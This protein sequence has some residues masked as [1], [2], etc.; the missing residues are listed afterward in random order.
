MQIVKRPVTIV[1]IKIQKR[2]RGNDIMIKA[3]IF[4]M[5]ETLIT[6]YECPLYF[7]AQMSKDAGIEEQ[8]FQVLWRPTEAERT[9]GK[10]T[11]EDILTKILEANHCYSKELLQTIVQKR[12]ATKEEC[13]RHLHNEILP[14]F[15]EIKKHGVKIGLISNCFSEE[16]PVI[17]KSILAPYFDAMYLSYEQGVKKPDAEIY[18]RC[19]NE[20]SVKPE[21]CIYIGDGGSNELEAAKH[22][23]MKAMQAAWY[24]KEGT[25]QP[26]RRKA[27]FIQLESPLE[28]ITYL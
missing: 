1:T 20:L 21:E 14:M 9:I 27:A 22:L 16:V 12:I 7:G 23:G 5:Y 6:H 18:K 11:F 3:V 13:F 28:V 19:M 17:R 24:L 4:D 25:L 15:K 10:M 2:N 8:S 26:A